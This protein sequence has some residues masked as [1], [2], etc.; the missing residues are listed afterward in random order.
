MKRENLQ[1]DYRI[2]VLGDVLRL[3]VSGLAPEHGRVDAV[4]TAMQAAREHGCH[5]ILFDI[6]KANRPD[7][8]AS[9]I[10][11]AEAAADMGM[12]KFRVALVGAP[13]SPL[14]KFIEDVSVNRGLPVRCFTDEAAAMKWLASHRTNLRGKKTK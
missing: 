7:F 11:H 1:P 2:D 13:G 3:E 8:H 5:G 6:R 4:K 10:Q 9:V 14:L 12:V